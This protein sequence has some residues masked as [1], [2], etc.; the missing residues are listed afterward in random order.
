[1]IPLAQTC[2]YHAYQIVGSRAPEFRVIK[3]RK[4]SNGTQSQE[5]RARSGGALILYVPHV[6][7]ESCG[8]SCFLSERPPSVHR[9]LASLHFPEGQRCQYHSTSPPPPSNRPYGP[10]GFLSMLMTQLSW[11]SLSGLR[12]IARYW[13]SLIIC[14][15]MDSRLLHPQ[16]CNDSGRLLTIGRII[17]CSTLG[18]L[19]LLEDDK[20]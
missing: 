9:S 13:V 15:N 16:E 11:T 5:T 3:R 2:A 7:H 10:P 12:R 4:R 20:A 17:I 18:H 1:M 14:P 6:L 8:S 19:G